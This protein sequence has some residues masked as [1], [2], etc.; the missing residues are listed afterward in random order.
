MMEWTPV[1]NKSEICAIQIHPKVSL[2][3]PV[4]S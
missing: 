4:R 1:L 2:S 3:N